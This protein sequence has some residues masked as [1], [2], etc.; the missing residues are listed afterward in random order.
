MHLNL[1]EKF[2]FNFHQTEQKLENK[3]RGVWVAV[4]GASK[5]ELITHRT[6]IHHSPWHWKVFS[7]I[8]FVWFGVLSWTENVLWTTRQKCSC[9]LDFNNQ[10]KCS[11]Y[12]WTIV[13]D[14]L[15]QFYWKARIFL[16]SKSC[17]SRR[18]FPIFNY[19]IYNFWRFLVK[20]QSFSA[21]EEKLNHRM[22][23]NRHIGQSKTIT[24][25][26]TRIPLNRL[27]EICVC[28]TKTHKKSNTKWFIACGCRIVSTTYTQKYLR[29]RLELR[30]NS[31]E[32]TTHS[33]TRA[34]THT[35][36]QAFWTSI[37]FVCK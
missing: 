29:E 4:N 33:Q 23:W 28:I 22:N 2:H 27:S 34:R 7:S 25:T 14:L 16:D 36:Q 37:W 1:F 10:N 26:T 21:Y 30:C 32:Q 19:L 31:K 15:F 11:Q 18:N 8:G 35:S 17:L 6:Q 24:R 12:E 3:K 20:T 5:R 9:H 13:C